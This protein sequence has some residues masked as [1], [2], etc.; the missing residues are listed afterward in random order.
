MAYLKKQIGENGSGRR[1][2]KDRD[3]E[4]KHRE[5]VEGGVRTKAAETARE[6]LRHEGFRAETITD[7]LGRKA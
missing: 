5:R 4:S 2:E 1:R 3:P 6:K 7:E